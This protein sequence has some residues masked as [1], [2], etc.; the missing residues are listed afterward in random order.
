MVNYIDAGKL[1]GSHPASFYVADE[2]VSSIDVYPFLKIGENFPSGRPNIGIDDGLVIWLE[3]NVDSTWTLDAYYGTDDP[4]LPGGL[5]HFENSEDSWRF[6]EWLEE[7]ENE[8]LCD[9]K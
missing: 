9:E 5:I 8:I 2:G 4:N 1:L 3:L 7:Y 6:L